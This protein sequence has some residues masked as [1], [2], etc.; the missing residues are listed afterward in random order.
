MCATLLLGAATRCLCTHVAS[1][2][3]ERC[4]LRPT[5]I[6]MYSHERWC[7]VIY[8]CCMNSC[9]FLSFLRSVSHR[10]TL[11][12][13]HVMNKFLGCNYIYLFHTRS[14]PE[15]SRLC[16]VAIGKGCW[17]VLSVFPV[18]YTV[19]LSLGGAAELLVGDGCCAPV[20]LL[21]HGCRCSVVLYIGLFPL[22]VMQDTRFEQRL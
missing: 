5:V 4:C 16:S 22:G 18:F 21:V 14:T 10:A 3:A 20:G 7:T 6:C 11:P 1:T 15:W 12:K 17:L 13:V 8:Y 9:L 2:H 19:E